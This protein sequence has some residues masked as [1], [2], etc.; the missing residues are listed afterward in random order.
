MTFQI[1]SVTELGEF[2]GKG[3]AEINQDLA[4]IG[5]QIQK[6]G[7]WKVLE[8][9]DNFCFETKNQF[10]QLKWKFSVLKRI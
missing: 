5:F 10:S 1:T 4:K 6:D 8:N 3:G 7:I 2:S 9:R